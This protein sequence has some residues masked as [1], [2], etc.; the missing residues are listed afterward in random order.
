[1]KHMPGKK[2]FSI[3]MLSRNHI[4]A[5]LLFAYCKPAPL[6]PNNASPININ[7]SEDKLT[8]TELNV[9]SNTAFGIT[10]SKPTAPPMDTALD[11]APLITDNDDDDD[12]V[13]IIEAAN[14]NNTE[15]NDIPTIIDDDD[16]DEPP[17]PTTNELTQPN[18]APTNAPTPKYNTRSQ[19]IINM[20]R[21]PLVPSQLKANLS[22]LNKMNDD[23]RKST[24]I[25]TNDENQSCMKPIQ[26]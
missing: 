10:M 25:V 23:I 26:I 15:P 21:I 11:N 3:D 4:P 24:K 14:D 16:D 2:I 9:L 1:M 12:N 20:G 19:T 18:Y 6:A 17:I 13:T 5:P 7:T 8:A 22:E